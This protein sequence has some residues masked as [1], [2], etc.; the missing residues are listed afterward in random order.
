MLVRVWN[1][2]TKI[3]NSFYSTN[4]IIL[5]FFGLNIPIY[6][7]LPVNAFTVFS[8]LSEDTQTIIQLLFFIMLQHT[9]NL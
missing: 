1:V 2:S 9:S 6:V 4:T 5:F 7:F 3:L 8:T